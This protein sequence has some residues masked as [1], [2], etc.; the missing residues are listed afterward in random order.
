MGDGG[1][2]ER[3]AHRKEGGTD[4]PPSAPAGRQHSAAGAG[5]F[6]AS[7][8]PGPGPG[9]PEGVAGALVAEPDAAADLDAAGRPPS[10]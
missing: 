3:F 1:G 8:F 10:S 5:A 6:A 7:P 4:A 9:V 2:A